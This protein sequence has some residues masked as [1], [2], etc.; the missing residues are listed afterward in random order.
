MK[1][2][3]TIVLLLLSVI[4]WGLIARKIYIAMFDNKPSIQ[5]IEKTKELK[6]DSFDLLLNY[7]DPFLKGEKKERNDTLRHKNSP[8]PD[9]N[10]EFKYKGII[11]IGKKTFILL[12]RNGEDILIDPSSKVDG[13]SIV[14]Y[15]NDEISLRDKNK[16]YKLAIE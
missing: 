14:K 15:S 9:N 10:P 3:V 7:R 5:T 6:S 13:Y 1:R 12:W 8:I 11:T 2:I 4:I 16:T